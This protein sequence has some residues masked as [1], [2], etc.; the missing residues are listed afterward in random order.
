MKKEFKNNKNDRER[1]HRPQEPFD[2]ES[3]KPT[4]RLGIQV[5]KKELTDIDV[6]LDNGMKIQEAEIVDA[7]LPELE[8]DI[9]LVGQAKGKF[10]GGQRRIFKQ[11]QKKTREGNKPNFATVAVVGNR[12]GY[13]GIGYGKGRETVPARE[14]AIRKAKLNIFKIRRGSGSWESTSAEPHSIPYMVNGKCGSIK[15]SIMPA[16]KGKGIIAEKECQKILA[17]AGIT[18]AWTKSQGHTATKSN[19]IKA[20]IFALQMLSK[21]KVR[22]DKL[23]GLGII[24]G[25]IVEAKKDE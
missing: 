10:G 13:V 6:I 11:T 19:M 21:T 8:T 14:K 15:I 17:L 22:E 23:K 2:I 24:E 9:L 7:L 18:D 1:G 3:W 20:C 25:K 4:T 16:P 12:N 5:K